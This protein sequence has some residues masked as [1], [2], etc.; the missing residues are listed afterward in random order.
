MQFVAY[1]GCSDWNDWMMVDSQ[2]Y[3]VIS[4]SSFK[5]A[6]HRFRKHSSCIAFLLKSIDSDSVS[7]GCL[8]SNHVKI[9]IIMEYTDARS[10]WFDFFNQSLTWEPFEE[11]SYGLKNGKLNSF[12]I[13]QL[14]TFHQ[15]TTDSPDCLYA[16]DVL[17]FDSP[18]GIHSSGGNKSPA[19][20]LYSGYPR[21]PICPE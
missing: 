20:R 19:V 14:T 3:S 17:R 4:R 1:F 6:S 21:I 5:V 2:M 13:R 11:D 16:P 12:V 10:S 7:Q 8:L 15:R 18:F 9:A